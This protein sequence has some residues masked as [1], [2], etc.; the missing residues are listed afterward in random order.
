ML[1]MV[2]FLIDDKMLQ[3][4]FV[5]LATAP[6]GVAIAPFAY[7]TGA[8]EKFSIFGMVGAYI[9]SLI[10]IPLCSLIFI[11]REFVNFGQLILIFAELI[12]APMIIAQILVK[13]RMEKYIIRWRGAIVN[14]G[15]FIVIFA[16]IYL[17]KSVIFKDFKSLGIISLISLITISLMW[18]LTALLLKRAKIQDK[19]RKSFILAAVIK[20]SGFSAA[21]ALSLFGEKASLPSAIFSVFLIIFLILISIKK[22]R[23]SER[24][25]F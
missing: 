3:T 23:K 21:A 2:Y 22:D 20:N 15:L 6:P 4:G 10:L 9:A 18:A 16:V 5:V 8:D 1:V 11:G 24:K 17:N 13:F 19:L 12:V 14:W 25:G 7:I